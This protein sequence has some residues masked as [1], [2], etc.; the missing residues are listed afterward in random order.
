MH[1]WQCTRIGHALGSFARASVSSRN[2][3]EAASDGSLGL[4]RY[5]I[6]CSRANSISAGESGLPCAVA[7]GNRLMI[8]RNG[9]LAYSTSRPRKVG[10]A[11]M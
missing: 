9:I 8:V 3:L 6:P 1:P 5:R 7:S 2:A 10:I 11:L 4:P